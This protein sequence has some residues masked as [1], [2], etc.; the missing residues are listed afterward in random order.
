[1]DVVKAEAAKSYPTQGGRHVGQFGCNCNPLRE[2]AEAC[3][4]ALLA[5]ENGTLL[6]VPLSS[7]AES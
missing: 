1:M 3:Y 7:A 6:F 5:V 2:H 4:L